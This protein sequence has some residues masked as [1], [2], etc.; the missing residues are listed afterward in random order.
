M[1]KQTNCITCGKLLHKFQQYFCSN[2]CKYKYQNSRWKKKCENCQKEFIL[3][4]N[5]RSNFRRKPTTRNFCSKICFQ[6]YWSEH[7]RKIRENIIK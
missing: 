2:E 6:G 3:A 5:R 4:E 7:W 1:D